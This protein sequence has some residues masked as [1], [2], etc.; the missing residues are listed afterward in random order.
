[1]KKD[2]ERINVLFV[3][4]GNICRSPMAEFY[5]RHIVAEAGLESRIK[6]ASAAVSSEEQGNPVYPNAK[7]KMA[8][9]G[10]GCGDKRACKITQSMYDASDY[11]IAM[12][13]SNVAGIRRVVKSNGHTVLSLLLDYVKSDDPCFCRNVA[14]PWYTRDFDKAWD[15]ITLGCDALLD[16]IRDKHHL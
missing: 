13:N 11:V 8:E 2:M 14:D 16:F 12:E 4:L 6:V 3:C 10:I 5:F 1:M 15:D 9:H 7:K